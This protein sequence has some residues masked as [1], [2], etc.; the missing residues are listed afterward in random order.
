MTL[1]TLAMGVPRWGTIVLKNSSIVCVRVERVKGYGK[2]SKGKFGDLSPTHDSAND[3]SSCNEC[4]RL[5]GAPPLGKSDL[6]VL[7]FVPTVHIEEVSSAYCAQKTASKVWRYFVDN[8]YMTHPIVYG[9]EIWGT[10]LLRSKTAVSNYFT[11]TSGMTPVITTKPQSTSTTPDIT[12]KSQS[13]QTASTSQTP[14]TLKPASTLK[15]SANGT[16]TA[17]AAPTGGA[18][19]L[20]ASAFIAGGLVGV[21][22][23]L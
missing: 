8:F 7:A 1:L 17:A 23:F 13:R 19:S 9:S 16:P 14:V 22:W 12:T 15:T 21:A 10:D 20:R 4:L 6:D 3:T 5:H 2:I 11:E 18:T